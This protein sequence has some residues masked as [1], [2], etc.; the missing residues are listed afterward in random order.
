MGQVIHYAFSYEVA[1]ANYKDQLPQNLVDSVLGWA[2]W[3]QLYFVI[4][5]IILWK[6]DQIVFSNYHHRCGYFITEDPSS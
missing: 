5:E 6:S 2:K 4:T 3:Y 1:D